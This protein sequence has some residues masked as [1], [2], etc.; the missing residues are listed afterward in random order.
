MESSLLL[1]RT[2]SDSVDIYKMVETAIPN[3]ISKFGL[4]IFIS[5]KK[6]F[7]QQRQLKLE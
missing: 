2:T 4:I 3:V 7:A 1:V 6:N 5:F